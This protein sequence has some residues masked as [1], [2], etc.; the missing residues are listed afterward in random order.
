VQAEKGKLREL[1]LNDPTAGIRRAKADVDAKEAQLE[2][3]R[4]GEDECALRAPVG[5]TVLRIL[6]GPGDVLGGRQQ[7]P[8][9]LFCPEGQRIVRAE[10]DQEFAGR[11]AVGQAVL[12]EDDVTAGP[13]WR[14]KVVRVSDW[15]TQRRSILPEPGQFNDVRTLECIIQ[16]DPGQPLLRIG[17]RVRA[18]LAR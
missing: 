9:V 7:Q 3:A 1:R 4:R 10:V 14:G 16:L 11:V 5:G 6:A 13:S 8:A 18:T 17:Q 15:Y 2:E 12:V